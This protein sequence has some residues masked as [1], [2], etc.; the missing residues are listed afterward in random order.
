MGDAPGQGPTEVLRS[1]LLKKRTGT[2]D[3]AGPLTAPPRH[4]KKTQGGFE[5]K[6]RRFLSIIIILL[7]SSISTGI[8]EN[9]ILYIC[10]WVQYD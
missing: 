8:K 6:S 5:N 3:N 1:R 9:I 7:L 2:V 4:P 10:L